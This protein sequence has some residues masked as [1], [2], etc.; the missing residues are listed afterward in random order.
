MFKISLKKFQQSTQRLFS[1]GLST[2]QQ[3]DLYTDQ[4]A[5]G[6]LENFPINSSLLPLQCA[7]LLQSSYGQ[8]AI[9]DMLYEHYGYK[10]YIGL[11][12]L[13]YLVAYTQNYNQHYKGQYISLT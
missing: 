11:L 8:L 5:S 2:K 1:H 4:L 3:A 7:N 13:P 6:S 10:I 9:F 12:S